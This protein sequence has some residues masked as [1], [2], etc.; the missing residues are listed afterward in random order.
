MTYVEQQVEHTSIT[1]KLLSCW[2]RPWGHVEKHSNEVQ[3][4]LSIAL[5]EDNPRSSVF[6]SKLKCMA[7]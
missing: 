1:V 7:N 5:S 2:P 3:G 4:W 6:F